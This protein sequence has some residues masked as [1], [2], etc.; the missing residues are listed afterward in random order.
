MNLTNFNTC[1][2]ESA[3]CSALHDDAALAACCSACKPL[4]FLYKPYS[5]TPV[6]P[7]VASAPP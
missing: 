3:D 2:T 1:P 7:P 6:T 4:I 5:Q